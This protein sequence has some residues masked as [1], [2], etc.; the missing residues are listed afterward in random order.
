MPAGIV[1]I[2][3]LSVACVGRSV[4]RSRRGRTRRFSMIYR[5]AGS[6]GDR[7]VIRYTREREGGGKKKAKLEGNGK[8]S[9]SARLRRRA[10]K[11]R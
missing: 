8:E 11:T 5:C 3:N 9:E 4:Y 7:I 1:Y 10:C 6:E 2:D